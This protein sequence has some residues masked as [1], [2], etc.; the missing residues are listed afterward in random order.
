MP[1]EYPLDV[2]NVGDDTYI[3]MSKGHHD[4]DA[5]MAA[6]REAGYGDWPLGVPKH[7]WVK[8]TPCPRSCGEHSCHYSIEDEK[9][10]GWFP[11]TYAWETDAA[12]LYKPP[13][14]AGVRACGG[15][16]SQAD[17]PIAG[18]GEAG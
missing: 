13:S 1:R 17:T 4:P 6:V 18:S 10:P 9:L 16:P 3:V 5:F 12:N 15:K 8:A 7:K 11:A 14:T 2:R